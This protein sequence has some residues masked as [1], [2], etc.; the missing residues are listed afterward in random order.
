T[1]DPEEAQTQEQEQ[2]QEQDREESEA[3]EPVAEI[4]EEEEVVVTARKREEN[5]Q[6]V[7]VAVTVTSGEV[8]EETSPPDISVLQD[9]VP[10]LSV[11]AARNQSTTM[12]AFMRGIGQA[13]PLWGVDPGVGLYLDG[14]YMARPQ[15]ALLDVYDVERVEVLRGPQGT[16]YGKNTI[17]GAIKY[18]TRPPTDSLEARIGVEGGN[19]S[20]QNVRAMVSGPLVEG[21]LRGKVSFASL[22]RDGFGT[23]RFTGR[24]VSDKDTTAYR[25]GLDWLPTDDVTVRLSADGTDDDSE[26]KGYQRLEANPFCP[27]FLGQPCPPLDDRFDV[28][29]GLAPLNGTES[30]G[31]ALT[32][33]WGMTPDWTFRSISAYRESDS[34]N[35]ID[36]D[37]TPAPITDVEATYFD[38]QTS[39]EFQFVYDGGGKLGGVLGLYYFDGEAGGEVLNNFL[40]TLFGITSGTVETRSY[41]IFG[42][43]SYRVNDRLSL[44]FGLRYTDEEK[45]GIAFNAGFTDATFSEIALVLADFDKTETFT[46]AAPRIG[47]DY[48]FSEDVMGYVTASR[49]FKSGGFNVRAQ[50]NFFPASAEPFD[51]EV[52]D[53]VEVGVKSILADRQ[54]VLNTA[55]FYGDYTDIQVSTFTA[56]DAD[57]DG[58]DDSFF[59]NFV[60]AGDATMKGLELEFDWNPRDVYWFGLQGHLSYLDAEP[61]TF[62]DRNND[63][64]VDTQ[65]ITNA[66]D[67]TGS[68]RLKF[69]KSA[70]GGLLTATIGANYRD[71]S[72]LTNEG[73]PDPRNPT[74][75]LQPLIQEA[76]ETVDFSINWITEEGHWGVKV[77]G[78]N[79]TDEEYLTNG[80]NIPVLGVV[81]GAYGAP[82]TITAGIQYR[83]F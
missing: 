55:A 18:E 21:K 52:L 50:S 82:S 39:Q 63:G 22:E 40:N 53:V 81:T 24:D 31:Y 80:Y 29:S 37:T 20:T 77:N 7:P 8:L 64:F 61:D 72:V 58:V 34:V 47:L 28:Q 41:A 68:L 46:S 19:Y 4:Q 5:V 30:E 62:L 73:G 59:G 23:N 44:N 12:T 57:G 35:N 42:D 66:P 76:Y 78:Y 2:E 56:F 26:P 54:L 43:G 51:D 70:F 9:Y 13:D 16:L 48:Q 17:G 65:V 75:P 71:D 36:F 69:N 45:R 3:D 25:I 15:G 67:Y 6:D 33:D 49:G 10:N 14:V 27:L 60:N 38:D 74:Q 11:Y 79:V 32:V 1:R 83:L